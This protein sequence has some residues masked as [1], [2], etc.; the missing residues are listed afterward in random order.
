M[1]PLNVE[2]L[3]QI[4]HSAGQRIMTYFQTDQIFVQKKSDQSP[5]TQ[6]DMASHHEIIKQLHAVDCTIPVLS[7]ESLES[8]LI[9][10]KSWSRY[11]LID[12]LDGTKEFIHGRREF[13]V[14]IALIEENSPTL[15][16]V[17]APPDDL[18][19]FAERGK[20]AF[21]RHKLNGVS[22]ALATRRVP[23]NANGEPQLTVLNS[24]Y[25]GHD[26]LPQ[27]LGRLKGKTSEKQVGSSLKV[28][29]IA[30]GKADLYPRLGPTSE[31]DTA[32]A[33]LV[34][35]EAG[36][37]VCS[38]NFESLRYNLRDHLKNDDFIALG[39]KQFDWKNWL[40][41]SGL[42]SQPNHS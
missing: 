16:V 30:E 35:E 6:A 22:Q 39:D 5:V 17:Y 18:F 4:A 12:P 38:L 19:Y 24:R 10:R 9:R 2:S 34:L 3:C 8:D 20:G 36:G 14:N 32:A 13:T 28:C 29:L 27:L 42:S 11:W 31:W 33:Q 37:Q 1:K 25:S 40:N 41:I 23:Q 15:S 7:E 21:T 26:R